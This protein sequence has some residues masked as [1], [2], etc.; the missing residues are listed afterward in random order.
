MFTNYENKA[1][2]QKNYK[3]KIVLNANLKDYKAGDTVIIDTDKSGI[4]LALY[5]RD[6]FKD[7]EI[8]GCIEVVKEIKNTNKSDKGSK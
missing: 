6:R 3:K 1:M 7:A 4:P 5:W 2:S 8:D